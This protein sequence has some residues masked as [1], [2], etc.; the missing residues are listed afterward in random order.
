MALKKTALSEQR[1]LLDKKAEEIRNTITK[2]EEKR[3]LDQVQIEAL[4]SE[5][6][7]IEG[8]DRT[9][10]LVTVDVCLSWLTRHICPQA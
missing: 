6:L 7:N 1:A 9:A 5:L 4:L 2:M 10:S 8:E 3:A